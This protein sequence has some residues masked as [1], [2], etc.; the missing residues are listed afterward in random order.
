MTSLY[1]RRV[2]FLEK[3][4]GSLSK[5]SVW[6]ATYTDRVV[7]YLVA[8]SANLGEIL[9]SYIVFVC[10]ILQGEIFVFSHIAC[11]LYVYLL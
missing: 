7:S 1:I 5:Y 4:P 6:F 3:W 11:I 9:P 10:F 2:L 8:Q